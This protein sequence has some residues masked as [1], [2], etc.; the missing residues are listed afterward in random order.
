[1]SAERISHAARLRIAADHPLGDAWDEPDTGMPPCLFCR[2]VVPCECMDDECM[3][4][5]GRCDAPDPG[6]QSS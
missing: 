5:C 1:M 4:S 3:C 2:R 6:E